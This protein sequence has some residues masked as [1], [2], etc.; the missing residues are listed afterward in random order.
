M[1]VKDVCNVDPWNDVVI[2]RVNIT[3]M[4]LRINKIPVE[5]D[6]ISEL[7]CLD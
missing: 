3:H 6:G 1:G 5:Y 2:H 7:L 4:H